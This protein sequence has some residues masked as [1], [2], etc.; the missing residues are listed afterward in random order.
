MPHKTEN[1]IAQQPPKLSK[2]AVSQSAE[3]SPLTSTISNLTSNRLYSQKIEW[4]Y[5]TSLSPKRACAKKLFSYFNSHIIFNTNSIR[6]MI[7]I[8]FF[9]Q[10]LYFVQHLHPFSGHLLR[11]AYFPV[12]QDFYYALIF[13]FY[14]FP[15]FFSLL[16][17]RSWNPV[18]RDWPILRQQPLVLCCWYQWNWDVQHGKICATSLIRGDHTFSNNEFCFALW[19]PT[20]FVSA[21]WCGHSGLKMRL[22]RSLNIMT[23]YSLD[24]LKSG[25]WTCLLV[26]LSNIVYF[27]GV[28]THWFSYSFFNINFFQYS[29][30]FGQLRIVHKTEELSLRLPQLLCSVTSFSSEALHV[31]HEVIEKIQKRNMSAKRTCISR[32]HVYSLPSIDLYFLEL[33]RSGHRL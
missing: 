18:D 23:H 9:K 10:I 11:V 24:A 33:F 27:K 20:F 12:L 19:P 31:Y 13:S 29:S 28:F 8:I 22:K 4:K 14:L 30:P 32:H 21:C 16:S 25:F 15:F 5:I 1:T 7:W 2:D 26:I 3:Q 17:L 6:V